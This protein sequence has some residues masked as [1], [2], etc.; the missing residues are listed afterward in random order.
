M[1]HVGTFKVLILRVTAVQ[2]NRVGRSLFP[3]T[4]DMIIIEEVRKF[5]IRK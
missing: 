3:E 4:G 2:D 5:P 1:I